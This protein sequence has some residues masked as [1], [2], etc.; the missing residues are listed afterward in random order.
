MPACRDDG[1]GRPPAVQRLACAGAGGGHR[2]ATLHRPAC[3]APPARLRR[4]AWRPPGSGRDPTRARWRRR[5]PPA[6]GASCPEGREGRGVGGEAG[7]RRPAAL[8]RL[9]AGGGA[10]LWT[11]GHYP[12]G[13]Q[14]QLACSRSGSAERFSR[15]NSLCA[16]DPARAGGDPVLIPHLVWCVR[17]IYLFIF[18]IVGVTIGSAPRRR[19]H[20]PQKIRFFGAF[21]T[22]FHEV[23]LLFWDQ[24]KPKNGYKYSHSSCLST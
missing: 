11:A 2:C 14:A 1:V 23:L 10:S 4:P 20:L 24:L 5:G 19:R 21:L 9:R 3:A 22:D 18:A 17:F 15:K 8:C 13:A 16:G 6:A 7:G 12:H